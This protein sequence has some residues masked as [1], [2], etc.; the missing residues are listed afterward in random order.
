MANKRYRSGRWYFR[1]KHRLLDRPLYV[2]FDD[3]ARGEDYVTRLE[4]MLDAGVVPKA[5]A[6]RTG[7]SE[8]RTISIVIEAY[9]GVSELPESDSLLL[10]TVA[11]RI[12]NRQLPL[13]MAWA[14][15][16]VNEMKTVDRLAPS[17]IRHQVGATARALDWLVRT[18]P[19]VQSVNPLRLLPKRYAS[20]RDGSIR[21][22]E[23]DRRL[24]AHEEL[25]IRSILAGAVPKGRERGL[26]V[27][28]N[29]T[30]IFDLALETAMRLREIFTLQRE[31][32]D[33]AKRTVFLERTK[34]GSSRQ[35]PLS[36]VAVARLEGHEG[37]GVMFPWVRDG[38]PE[39]LR[40]VTSLLSRR[41]GTVFRLAGCDDLNF[42][43]L[44]HEATCRL[45]LRTKLSDVQIARITGHKDLRTLRRYASLRGS[46]LAA[47]L[48]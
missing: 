6:A 20:Y 29:L 47:Q 33:L 42:H 3:E 48:W 28:P 14:E 22:V 5:V 25:A 10:R 35:V 44:R 43:D 23:R 15:N 7:R 39:D 24:A 36:T 30:L 1:V 41:F 12:G 38:T 11:D 21:D 4:S 27:D 9:R 13:D 17:T 19:T 37:Q 40:R 45:Y 8:F 18:R 46:D 2:S 26:V 16:W 32:I 34:N 31:Q